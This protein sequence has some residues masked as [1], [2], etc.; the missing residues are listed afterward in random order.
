MKISKE[1]L[2]KIIKE[3]LLKENFNEVEVEP[4]KETLEVHEILDLLHQIRLSLQEKAPEIIDEC[5]IFIETTL[6]FFGITNDSLP[7]EPIPG[8]PRR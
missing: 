8:F 7:Q 4:E 6:N 5:D 1:K 3:E 2:R